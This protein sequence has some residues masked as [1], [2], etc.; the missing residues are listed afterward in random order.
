MK[1]KLTQGCIRTHM[2]SLNLSQILLRVVSAVALCVGL[3]A[4]VAAQQNR[5]PPR[6]NIV[7]R[8]RQPAP[9]APKELEGPRP[10]EDPDVKSADISITATVKAQSLRLDRKSTRLNSSH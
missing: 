7:P 4:Q 5:R 1:G 2:V 9:P 10:S 8:A 6:R 3:T